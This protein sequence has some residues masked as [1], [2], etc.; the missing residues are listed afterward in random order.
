M[1]LKPLVLSALLGLAAADGSHSGHSTEHSVAASTQTYTTAV[2]E[3]SFVK[4]N[5]TIK[6]SHA[7]STILTYS[8]TTVTT[9]TSKSTGTTSTK[10]NEV[11]PPTT[12]RPASTPTSINAAG[13]SQF[14]LAVLG[15]AVGAGLVL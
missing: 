3:S 10:Q 14:G 13:R 6:T 4:S 9:A 15:L 2:I 11:T 8:N 5:S 7:S 1:Q 12:T